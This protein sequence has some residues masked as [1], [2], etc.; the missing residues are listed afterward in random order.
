MRFAWNAGLADRRSLGK[1]RPS[2]PLLHIPKNRQVQQNRY[3]L[4]ARRRAGSV[5]SLMTSSRQRS[6]LTIGRPHQ[7]DSQAINTNHQGA[8]AP[9]SPGEWGGGRAGFV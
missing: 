4:P 8:Y 3:I 5:S 6:S 2:P 9:R 1:N 7:G